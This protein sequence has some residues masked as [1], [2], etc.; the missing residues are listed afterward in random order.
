M[1][2]S[3]GQPLLFLV[4]LGFGLEPV[5]QKAG[6]GNY[7]QFLIPGIIAMGIIF[8]ALFSG[9]EIIWDR[10]FGFLKETLVAPV[11]RLNIMIGRTLG[12]ATVASFAGNYHSF[13]FFSCRISPSKYGN[14][15]VSFGFYIPYS[16]SFYCV[17]N[18]HC[19]QIARH[20]GIPAYYEFFSDAA[21]FPFG[22]FVSFAGIAQSSWHSCK[23][24]PAF[25]RR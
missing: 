13:A 16:P 10:Q 25:L 21:F 11:S 1:I 5:Y 6:G 7:I 2:G 20:A 22:S 3:L 9:I 19:F 18:S 24:R 4:A 14:F 17:G 12:G 23:F 8:T 15:S